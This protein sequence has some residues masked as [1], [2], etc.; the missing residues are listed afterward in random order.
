MTW[1][2][3]FLENKKVPQIGTDEWFQCI[4]ASDRDTARKL[5][6][7]SVAVCVAPI[8]G[9]WK[10]VFEDTEFAAGAFSDPQ[11][12]EEFAINWNNRHAQ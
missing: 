12:A 1:I 9:G 6:G 4:P 2:D 8:P 7:D 11:M 3:N 10:V 5:V